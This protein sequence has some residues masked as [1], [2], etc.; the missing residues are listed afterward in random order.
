MKN[1]YTTKIKL[2]KIRTFLNV[3]FYFQ[4]DQSLEFKQWIR[5]YYSIHALFNLWDVLM[6]NVPS[7]NDLLSV[8][9]SIFIWGV[10]IFPETICLHGAEFN[11]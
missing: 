9:G 4:S 7:V 1:K 10:N 2:V 11:G 3:I 6:T 8:Y 5:H